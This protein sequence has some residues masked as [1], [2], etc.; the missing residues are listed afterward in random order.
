MTLG[1]GCQIDY[2]HSDRPVPL[3][4]DWNEPTNM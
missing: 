1:L 3:P 2:R 4:W